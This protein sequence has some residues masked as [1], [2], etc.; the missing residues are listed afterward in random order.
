[1]PPVYR[2]HPLSLALALILASSSACSDAEAAAEANA[3]AAEAKRTLATIQVV[4]KNLRGEAAEGS[5]TVL[6]QSVLVSGRALT[7]NEALRKVPGVTV[8]DEEGFGLRPNIGIRGSNPTRSTK[9]H[10]AL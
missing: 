10:P 8:R 6:D 9:V 1:M 4:E 7:V 2:P 5:S 3:D